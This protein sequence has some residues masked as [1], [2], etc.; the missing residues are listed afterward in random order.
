MTIARLPNAIDSSWYDCLARSE[1]LPATKRNSTQD[2]TQLKAELEK[3]VDLAVQVEYKAKT[4]KINKEIKEL[5]LERGKRKDLFTVD[6]QQ[7]RRK[8]RIE[9][10]GKKLKALET[11][12]DALKKEVDDWKCEEGNGAGQNMD[13]QRS[14]SSL[15]SDE[16]DY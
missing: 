10:E 11:K 14:S 7:K 6:V 8:L 3:E 16:E 5:E 4:D 1:T 15:H 2:K 12:R 9:E 13:L